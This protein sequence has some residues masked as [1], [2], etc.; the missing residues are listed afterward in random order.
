MRPGKGRGLGP[1][2]E[3]MVSEARHEASFT[4]VAKQRL[5]V[6]IRRELASTRLL[7]SLQHCGK[8]GRVDLF[9]L[10]VGSGVVLCHGLQILLARGGC[11][12][13]TGLH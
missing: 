2:N 4:E 13:D 9:G 3:E 5:D 11:K 10:R 6:L 12:R 7:Q 1:S 8:V